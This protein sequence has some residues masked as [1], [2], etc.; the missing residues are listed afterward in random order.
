MSEK[1]V[2][3]P[4]PVLGRLKDFQRRTV[5][6][7]FR[8]LY[9]DRPPARRFLVADEVGLGKTLVARGLIARALEHYQRTQ[10]DL[11]VDVVYVC[12][13]A[14]IAA[15][16]INRLNVTGQ[17]EFAMASRLTLLPTRVHHLADNRVN[18]VSFTPG[19]TFELRSSGG[20]KFE[21]AIL[22][23]IL[24]E[25]DGLSEPGLY[26]ML[27]GGAGDKGWREAAKGWRFSI[28]EH[29]A[30]RY[31]RAIAASPELRDEL[32]ARVEQF[33]AVVEEGREPP[34]RWERYRT[35]GR[36]RQSLARSCLDALEPDLVILDE[37]QRFKD[38]MHGDSEAADLA[39]SLFTYSDVRVLLLSATP[40]KMLT[41]HHER[42]DDHYP[43]FVRTLRFLFDDDEA[44]LEGLRADLNGFRSALFDLAGRRDTE[45]I[46]RRRDALQGRLLRVMCRTERVAMTSERDAMLAEPPLDAELAPA[47][48]EQAA[49]LDAVARA[50]SAYDTVEY[51]KSGPHVLSFT[52]RYKL[53]HKV[54]RQ[55]EEP[56][57]ALREALRR[58]QAC[59][60]KQDDIEGYARIEPGNA[61]L[62]ALWGLTL[63]RDL[64]RV[65]WMP[66]SLPYL[67]P[68]GAFRTL[69]PVTK[70]LVFSAWNFVPDAIAALTSYEAERLAVDSLGRE[71]FAHAALY[72]RLKPLLRFTKETG[73][74]RLTG[75]PT[76]ALLAPSPSLAAL[77]DPLRLALN[78]REALSAGRA[79]GTEA[80][81]ALHADDALARTEARVR[82]RLAP[83][84]AGAPTDGPADERWYWASL[85]LLDRGQEGAGSAFRAWCARRDGW[86]EVGASGTG[87]V[88][89]GFREHLDLFLEAMEG[90]LELGRPPDDLARV[91]AELAL[92]GPGVCSLRAIQRTCPE[93][94]LDDPALLSAA[95]RAAGGFRTLYNIPESIALLRGPD[96]TKPYW[97]LALEHGLDGNLQALL[98]EQVH[99]LAE[100]L[101]VRDRNPESRAERIGEALADGL[102]IRTSQLR[103]DELRAGEDGQRFEAHGF[104]T[105]CRFALRFGQLQDDRDASIARADTVRTAFNSPFRPFVLAS[106]SIGQEGLDFHMWCHAVVHWNLPS[107][108]VDLEQ[109]EGRVHRYKGHAVRKN[110]SRRFG[111]DGLADRWSPGSDPWDTL[112]QLAIEERDADESELIPFWIYET[113]G[114]ARIQRLVPRLP[115]SREVRRLDG[116]KQSLALYRLVF[117]QPRQDDLLAHLAGRIAPEEAEQVAQEWRVSLLPP[118][119][120]ILESAFAE[121][122]RAS[123]SSLKGGTP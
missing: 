92:A 10:P 101:G 21:R 117:G 18:F 80:D 82:G 88:G 107:N 38:L 9:Q 97:R 32:A 62:R 74:G 41:L 113:D 114:G 123:E 72:D 76:L 109:R 115:F 4:G 1:E 24:R 118:G 64:W 112:F 84:L 94:P 70:A 30:G 51:W 108:P 53:R 66:P 106:T 111:L 98:D 35:I 100:A 20:T 6:Y 33:R 5:D 39:R 8:R 95:A 68:G 61:R 103:V 90:Q 45:P 7:V 44:A 63:E 58:A 67:R 3:D 25:V 42:D 23:R 91:L 17:R 78:A 56:S 69:G 27:Q 12:S 83:L 49:A 120:D 59:G 40:Y 79:N 2:F 87:R 15:Q 48:L 85:A 37:F 65:L 60:L 54:D 110:V 13:N 31:R 22:Y 11:R 96:E 119:A 86:R 57:D 73:T 116:L 105:R 52:R 81:A 46:R 121:G 89:E 34:P 29:L 50:A 26:A 104:N 71:P 77:V 122:R 55:M 93:R 14:A 19:T 36:L 102:S 16:N 43:D 28:D 47:D 75:M 99:I